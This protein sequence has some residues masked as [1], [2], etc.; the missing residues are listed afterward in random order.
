M[1]PR[2]TP[3]RLASLVL[4]LTCLAS[5]SY[6]SIL[7]LRNETGDDLVPYPVVTTPP[8]PHREALPAGTVPH[9][10]EAV[11][12]TKGFNPVYFQEGVVDLDEANGLYLGFDLIDA[13]PLL[14]QYKVFHYKVPP[15]TDG[16]DPTKQPILLH[17]G[18]EEVEDLDLTILVTTKADIGQGGLPPGGWRVDFRRN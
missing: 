18:F 5:C 11:L 17:Q 7:R 6:D 2:A 16:G 8:P 1:R 3:S 10:G 4:A 12:D 9:Q 13:D 15:G 14:I